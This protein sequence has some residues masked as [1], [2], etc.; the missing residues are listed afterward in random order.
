MPDDSIDPRLSLLLSL[1]FP[2]CR[3][4]FSDK[5]IVLL[6]GGKVIIKAKPS[7]PDPP[8]ESLRHALTIHTTNFEVFRPEE[9][10][11]W[12]ADGIFKDLMTFEL[13]L[14]SICS[15]VVIILESEGSLVELGA[16]SQ[17]TELSNKII[18][19]CPEKYINDDSFIRLGI[20]RFISATNAAHVKSYPW[21]PK[22]KDADFVISTEIVEDATSDI[23]DELH[24]LPKSQVLKSNKNSHVMVLICELLRL[25]TALKESE[26]AEYLE[27]CGA[28]VGRELLR[29]KLFLLEQFHLIRTQTYSDALF[30]FKGDEQF[31]KLRLTLKEDPKPIDL[32]RIEMLCLE[33]YKSNSKHRNRLRAIARADGGTRS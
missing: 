27:L 10:D 33:Y 23:E 21:I 18:A 4:E 17:L 1:D 9:I 6:C 3:V 20:L 26:I 14:A 16:F 25:F 32:L 13:E 8:L 2:L 29:G 19:I 31:H 5:P 30:Y 22:Q 12:Q 7:D 15:M 11:T 24:K 28:Q